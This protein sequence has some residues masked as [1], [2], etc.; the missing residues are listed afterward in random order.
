[1]GYTVRYKELTA[2]FSQDIRNIKIPGSGI[3]IVN[4]DFVSDSVSGNIFSGTDYS[5]SENLTFSYPIVIPADESH[6]VILML[7]GLNERSWDKYLMWAEVL[8]EMTGSYVILFPISFHINRSPVSWKDP[9]SMLRFLKE[10]SSTRGETR[11]SS[12]ANIAL[13]NRLSD[14]PRRFLKSGYQTVYDL[15]KLIKQINAGQHTVIPAE[16]NVNIFAYSIGAFLAEIIMMANPDGLFSGSKLFMFCGGSVFSNMKGESKLIMD[17]LA[18]EKIYN[19]YLERFEEEI[20][21]RGSVLDHL[22]SGRIGMAFR[23]MIDFNRFRD[24]R[25]K[26]LH[27]LE[28]RIYSI[29][30]KKDTVIPAA[31]IVKTLNK[32]CRLEVIDFTHDYTHENPFPVINNN[33]HSEVD[34]S[35]EKVFEPACRFLE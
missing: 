22:V 14:D 26:A 15:V 29:G 24:T 2:A 32:N 30:L 16:S 12:F 35:F 9:R 5:I 33:G 6:K 27:S 19:Y 18:Y 4:T 25:E 3:R 13:S 23:S 28:D 31:G 7:H 1:M 10:K 21:A 17:K 8:A 20:K 34:R 11:S